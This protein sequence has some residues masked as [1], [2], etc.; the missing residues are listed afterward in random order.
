MNLHHRKPLA[1]GLLA[2]SLA[3]CL[4]L[5][6]A[7]PLATRAATVSY[8]NTTAIP[9]F[10]GFPANPST[11][12]INVPAL[13]GGL[14][15]LTV[16]AFGVTYPSSSGIELLLQGPS[17]QGI[18]LMCFAGSGAA[19][20]INITFADSGSA[21]GGGQLTTGSYQPTGSSYPSYSP[22]FQENTTNVLAGFIGATLSGTWT[23]SEYYADFAGN[24]GSIAG[25]WSLTFNV[26]QTTPT[27]ATLPATNITAGNATLSEVVIPNGA[28]TSEYFQY[29][30]TVSYGQFTGTN[31]ISTD[32]SDPQT[33]SVVATV[34]PGSI[35]HFRAVAQNSF[36]TVF[37]TDRT[38]TTPVSQILVGAS[39]T[40]LTTLLL[41]VNGNIGSNYIVLGSTNLSSPANW[42]PIVT[43]TLTNSLQ[44]IYVAPATNSMQFFEVEQH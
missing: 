10:D 21:F 32:L 25:G 31:T 14:Q 30:T 9:I 16:T 13:P 24:D 6:L 17:G 36:G 33:N 22:F 8:T 15:S 2:R 35:I 41:T 39:L 26:V 29:G 1:T 18:N 11:S 5:A 19:T 3:V 44:P 38:F 27:V 40:N 42:T 7:L 37:G 12:T 4:V 34:P 23:L 20:N 43:N 28:T